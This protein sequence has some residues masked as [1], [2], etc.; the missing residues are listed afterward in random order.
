MKVIIRRQFNGRYKIMSST[1]RVIHSDR[2][3]KFVLGYIE[4]Q[5]QNGF[6]SVIIE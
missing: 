4:N 1:G 2:D 6:E 5:L 3:L